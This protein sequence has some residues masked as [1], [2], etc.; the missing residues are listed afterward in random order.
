M[1][2]KIKEKLSNL[3]KEVKFAIVILATLLMITFVI[4]IFSDAEASGK[5]GHDITINNYYEY[6]DPSGIQDINYL[7]G[8]SINN[9]SVTTGVSDKDLQQGLAAALAGGSHQF[10]Y[11]TTDYQA[12]V[13]GVWEMSSENETGYS[14]GFGKRFKE[15]KYIPDALFHL[16]YTPNDDQ[17]YVGFGATFRIK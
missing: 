11:S 3:K 15:H 1:I 7:D 17:D 14:F 13:V 9:V 4:M 12:S 8:G 10:D 2:D 16:S 5:H 6:P